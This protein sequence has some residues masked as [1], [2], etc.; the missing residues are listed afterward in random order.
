MQFTAKEIQDFLKTK[1]IKKTIQEISNFIVKMRFTD[2]TT[3]NEIIE[4]FK[5]QDESSYFIIREIQTKLKARK[6]KK[7]LME[8]SDYIY[9]K[10][11][12]ETINADEIV[13]QLIKESQQKQE[14]E[15]IEQRLK[16]EFEAFKQ[17]KLK[18][19]KVTEMLHILDYVSIQIVENFTNQLIQEKLKEIWKNHEK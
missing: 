5:K 2:E 19:E 10:N 13:E 3:F 8:I 16:Y 15:N 9:N 11:F 4:E 6:I 1:G 7:N 12:K 17:K 18:I 14:Q